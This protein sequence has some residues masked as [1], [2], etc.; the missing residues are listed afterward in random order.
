VEAFPFE[1]Q[2][3]FLLHDRDGIYG[4]NFRDRVKH[5]GIEEVLIAFRSP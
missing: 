1:E 2:P 4:R 5:L 3:R